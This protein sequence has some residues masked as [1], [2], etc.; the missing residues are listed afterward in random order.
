MLGALTVPLSLVWWSRHRIQQYSLIPREDFTSVVEETSM[1]SLPFPNHPIPL[2][3][4]NTNVY[5]NVVFTAVLAG[6][7]LPIRVRRVYTTLTLTA[8]VALY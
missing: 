6:T 1:L 3:I 2:I 4:I 8:I 5:A 7:V